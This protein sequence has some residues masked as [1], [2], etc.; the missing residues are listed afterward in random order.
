MEVV[1]GG[2]PRRGVTIVGHSLGGVVAMELA[3]RA[4]LPIEK[5][6]L[7]SPGPIEGLVT[8]KEQY[9]VLETYRTNRNLLKTAL[10]TVVPT[11]DDVDVLEEL[12]DEGMRM[13]PGAFLGHPDALTK[14]DYT[15]RLGKL[16][17]PSMIIR[18]NADRLITQEMCTRTAW[19]LGAVY[20]EL[21]GVGHSPMV[22][23]PGLFLSVLKDFVG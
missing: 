7:V 16:P 20:R 22:E 6:L 2:H 12:V 15:D 3:A 8:P 13:H 21:S 9:P 23:D 5:M 19:H 18:G 14:A 1:E 10:A 11:L 4:E 17:F